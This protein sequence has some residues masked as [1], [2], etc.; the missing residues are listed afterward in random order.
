MTMTEFA[1]ATV[2]EPAVWALLGIGVFGVGAAMRGRRQLSN[3][4]A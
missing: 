4:H 3:S 2:P 1:P